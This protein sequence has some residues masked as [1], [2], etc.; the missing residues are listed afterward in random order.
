MQCLNKTSFMN[1]QIIIK[2]VVFATKLNIIFLFMLHL[3][4][5]IY[6]ENTSIH[7]LPDVILEWIIQR[8]IPS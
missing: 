8:K 5:C 6:K 1:S 2:I 7:A 3:L 4:V